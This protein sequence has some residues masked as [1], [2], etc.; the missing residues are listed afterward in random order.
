[1]ESSTTSGSSAFGTSD[2]R[3]RN[4]DLDRVGRVLARRAD[5]IQRPAVEFGTLLADPVFWGWNVPR[6][7]SHSVFVL[8]GLGG[9]DAYL[10]PMRG[11]LQRIGYRPMRSGLRFNPGWSE[12][13]VEEIGELIRAEFERSGSPVTIIGHSMGGVIGRSVA[14]RSPYM[15]RHV[16]ALASPLIVARSRLSAS[17]PITA[18]FSR[19]DP[20]VRHPAGLARD[21][22][23]TNIEV[24]GSHIGMPANPEVYRRLGTLLRIGRVGDRPRAR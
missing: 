5:Q 13:L 2:G 3:G 17:V 24:S 19:S 22:H 23:A 12:E 8:P 6:G 1:M 7:D 15:I 14:A 4:F 20:I 21:P 18:L 16:V 9:G 11:W 10:T